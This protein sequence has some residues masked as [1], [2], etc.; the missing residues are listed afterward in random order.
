MDKTI[1]NNSIKHDNGLILDLSNEKHGTA[2]SHHKANK[3]R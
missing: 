2:Q 3:K 1:T